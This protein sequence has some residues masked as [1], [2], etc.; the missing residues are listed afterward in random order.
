MR[1]TGR[2]KSVST[3]V[4]TQREILRDVMLSAAECDTWLTLRELSLLTRYGEASISAQLRHLRKPRY[5]AFVIAKQ[6]RRA[7]AI[8]R[9]E[10]RGPVVWEYQLRRGVPRAT[11]P[12][13]RPGNSR[14]CNAARL[15]TRRAA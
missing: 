12:Q 4:P 9:E 15:S 2:K 7:R 11:T 3:R 5:G 13:N 14:L 6:H 10:G 8:V 1:R